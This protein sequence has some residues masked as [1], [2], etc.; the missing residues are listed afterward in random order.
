MGARSRCG[1]KGQAD[2]VDELA[3]FA[4]PNSPYTEAL[5]ALRTALLLAKSSTPPQLLLVTSS[6]AGEGKSILSANLSA[7]LAQGGKRVLLVDA[8]LRKPSL[9]D[10]LGMHSA[11]GLSQFLTDDHLLEDIVEAGL[12]AEAASADLGAD[13]TLSRRTAWL[14]A[15]G[16][17]DGAAG[18]SLT[19]SS[20]STVLRSCWSPIRWCWPA[21]RTPPCW[22]RDTA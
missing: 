6:V 16:G 4:H 12:V 1:E 17:G 15:D 5:R 10:R 13:S 14:G 2:G 19:I 20:F 3:I 7:V 9:A 22:W 18:A 21:W 11:I 8:D